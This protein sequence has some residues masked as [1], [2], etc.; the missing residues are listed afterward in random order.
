MSPDTEVRSYPFFIPFT[1]LLA[2]LSPHSHPCFPPF[3][4]L[5]YSQ[6]CTHEVHGCVPE[7]GR[8]CGIGANSSWCGWRS[9]HLRLYGQAQ[10]S[11][12]SYRAQRSPVV[13]LVG[14]FAPELD[15]VEGIDQWPHGTSGR[16]GPWSF[17]GAYGPAQP[18]RHTQ[19]RRRSARV[20]FSIYGGN[21]HVPREACDSIFIKNFKR[22]ARRFLVA[23]ASWDLRF[24]GNK[25]ERTRGL[26]RKMY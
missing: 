24:P 22:T 16:S 20:S 7:S 14:H 2:P 4:V 18:Q 9:A 6:V 5:P 11:C 8:A 15:H 17:C 1:P 19:A 26:L 23:R 10:H 3:F 25:R 21:N 12:C 13:K